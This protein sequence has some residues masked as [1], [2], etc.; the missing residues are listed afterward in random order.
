MHG[1]QS[2]LANCHCNAEASADQRFF[3]PFSL[4][5]TT[6]SL[7]NAGLSELWHILVILCVGCDVVLPGPVL[8]VGPPSLFDVFGPLG[9]H[10]M[11][12]GNGFYYA[13]I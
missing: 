2:L 8:K 5:K 11:N 6:P 7:S 9:P 12:S 3:A 13:Y 10:A 4:G 1:C